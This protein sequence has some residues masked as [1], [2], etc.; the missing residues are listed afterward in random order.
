MRFLGRLHGDGTLVSGEGTI[1]PVAFELDGYVMR[2]GSVV[3]SGELRM[4]PGQLEQAAH[5]RDLRLLMDDGRALAL[6]ITGKPTDHKRGA[7]HVDIFEGLPLESEW[8]R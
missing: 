4:A 1:G 7:V 6:R 3:A 2:P 5:R 8:Q